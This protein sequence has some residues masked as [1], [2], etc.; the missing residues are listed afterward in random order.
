VTVLYVVLSFSVVASLG[1][2]CKG[3]LEVGSLIETISPE[4][5]FVLKRGLKEH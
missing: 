5:C 3:D 4:T 2:W 1:I